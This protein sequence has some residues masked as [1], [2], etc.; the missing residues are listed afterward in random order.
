MKA[1]GAKIDSVALVHDNTEYG[2]SVAS[3][4]TSVFK[5]KGESAPIDIAYA[6]NATD[7]QSPGA[8]AQGEEARR[9]DHDQLHLGRDPVRQDH[10]GAGLQAARC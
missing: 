9:R 7:V 4:I 1:A 6:P 5:E 10:A 2:T 8:A 3:V